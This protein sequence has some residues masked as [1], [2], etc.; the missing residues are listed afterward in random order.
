MLETTR[1]LLTETARGLKKKIS[2]SSVLYM[3]F[4]AMIFFSIVMFAFLTFFLLH[5][6]TVVNFMDVFYSVFFLLLMKSAA[7]MHTY[8]I[9][10]PRA[11]YS[12][13]P[14]VGH[15]K[16]VGEITLTIVL[17]NCGI[18]FAFSIL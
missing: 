2:T 11:A 7:D 4:I 18:W 16:T 12:L 14:A 1:L 5:T 9:T 10:S 15:R 6:D 8:F 13:S 17:I 3:F